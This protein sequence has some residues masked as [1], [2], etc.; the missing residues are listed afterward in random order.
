MTVTKIRQP[1]IDSDSVGTSQIIATS[2]VA[3]SYTLASITVDA[4]GRLTAA[5]NGSVAAVPT[6][7]DNEVPAGAIDGTNA[8]FTLATT[9]TAGS[10]HAYLNGVRMF[11]GAGNDYTI[12][13]LTI[14]M[15]VIP[16]TG[17]RLTTDYRY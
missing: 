15:L 5:S 8:S 2:V 17:D 12:S 16:K 7:V 14:T 13:G 1:Q 3:A 11:P 6:F 4:D 9:P 10:T